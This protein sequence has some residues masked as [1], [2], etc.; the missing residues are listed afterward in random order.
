M[1]DLREIIHLQ[2]LQVKYNLLLESYLSRDIL[3][4]QEGECIGPM[5]KISTMRQYHLLC[6]EIGLM[7]SR[8][9]CI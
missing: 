8:D 5:T 6:P 9:T 2:L 1:L 7:R 4:S 3:R